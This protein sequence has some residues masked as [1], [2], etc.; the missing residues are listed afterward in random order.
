MKLYISVL[1]TSCKTEFDEEFKKSGNWY[2]INGSDKILLRANHVDCVSRASEKAKF[3]FTSNARVHF[4]LVFIVLT[5]FFYVEIPIK[6]LIRAPNSLVGVSRWKL[7]VTPLWHENGRWW[8]FKVVCLHHSK[9]PNYAYVKILTT[10]SSVSFKA[11]WTR[12]KK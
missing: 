6:N 7:K 2:L 4:C 8:G 11:K 3:S 10:F 12:R 9:E 5:W 1:G